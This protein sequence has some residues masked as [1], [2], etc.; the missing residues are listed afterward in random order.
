M[1]F[2]LQF[3]LGAPSVPLRPDSA[4]YEPGRQR[5]Q[6]WCSS[7]RSASTVRT[8]TGESLATVNAA[9][10]RSASLYSVVNVVIEA[11]VSSVASVASEF[12]QQSPE[13]PLP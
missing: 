10:F 12:G 7:L 8:S 4:G 5:W 2:L 9:I 3:G 1:I 11:R 6:R 13:F